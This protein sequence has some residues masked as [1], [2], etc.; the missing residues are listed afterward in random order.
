MRETSTKLRLAVS[1]RCDRLSFR[2]LE[3]T[4][5]FQ[6]LFATKESDLNG[7]LSVAFLDDAEISDLHGRFLN[8]PIPTDVIT[9]PGETQEDFA[10]EIC[11]S[12][13]TAWRES[14]ERKIPFSREVCLYLAHGWLHLNGYDDYDEMDRLAMRE[15]EAEALASAEKNGPLPTFSFS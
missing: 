14:R 8:E 5:F 13:E 11:V 7:E 1:N 3:V 15:A 9:F 10:G 2:D 12:V 4:L 6:A